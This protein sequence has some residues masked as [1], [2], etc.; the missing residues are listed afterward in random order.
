LAE[1]PDPTPAPRVRRLTHLKKERDENYRAIGRY[2]AQFSALVA[3][4]RTL[5]ILKI[6]GSDT[7]NERLL[8]LTLGSLTAQQVSDAFFAVC[9][10]AAEPALT[11]DELRIEKV[12]RENHVNT[13]IRRRNVLAHGDWFIPEWVQEWAPGPQEEPP[14]IP[15]AALVRVQHHKPD[16][17]PTDELPVDEIDDYGQAVQTLQQIIWEFGMICLRVSQYDPASGRPFVRVGEAFEL[18]GSANARE[19]QWRGDHWEALV[20]RARS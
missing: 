19:V 15:R 17:L 16:P 8:R 5:I 10:T 6:A 13:E 14:P 9:R 18:A 4:M 12:L 11:E 3:Y 2:F 1:A 7:E 20:A